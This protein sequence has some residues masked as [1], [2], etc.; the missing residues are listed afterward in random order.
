[1]F[2]SAPASTVGA[3]GDRGPSLGPVV[4]ITSKLLTSMVER[5]L[6]AFA[7]N[8]LSGQTEME[9]KPP[10]LSATSPPY[11]LSARHTAFSSIVQPLGMTKLAFSRNR[12]P[13]AG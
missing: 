2:W 11:F 9:K 6:N 8:R 13:I 1:M 7:G 5:L 12:C 4:W 3:P 10:L